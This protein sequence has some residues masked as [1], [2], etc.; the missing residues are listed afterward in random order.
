MRQKRKKEKLGVA[1]VLLAKVFFWGWEMSDFGGGKCPNFGGGKSPPGKW[2]TILQNKWVDLLTLQKMQQWALFS[3]KIYRTGK[4]YTT[5]SRDKFQR[6]MQV[7]QEVQE[8]QVL[9]VI[10]VMLIMQLMHVM[11][12]MQEVHLWVEFQVVSTVPQANQRFSS[13][14]N[15]MEQ[16]LW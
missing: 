12:E 10:Q 3:E 2:L 13:M 16:Q 4:S 1:A 6:W 11:Q 8:M 15:V 5:A 14:K 7:V 9:Q